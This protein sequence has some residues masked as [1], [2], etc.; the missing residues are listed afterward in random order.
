MDAVGAV[1]GVAGIVGTLGGVGLGGLLTLRRER[2]IQQ[3]VHRREWRQQRLD[4]CVEYLAAYRQF[5]GRLFVQDIQV[6]L[7][8]RS[9]LGEEFAFVQGAQESIDAVRRAGGRL[10][11]LE[12]G[13]SPIV[14]AATRIT[15]TFEALAVARGKQGP[16]LLPGDLVE[17]ARDA[18][19]EFARVV[20]HELTLD[21]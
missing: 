3:I 9:P 20:Q 14:D 1:V 6:T 2:L 15:K 13:A 18:E 10:L 16:G 8:E 17:A 4:A 7:S 5:R 11:L 19:R 21:L 12:A